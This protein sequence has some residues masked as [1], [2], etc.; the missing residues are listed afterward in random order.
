VT[1]RILSSIQRRFAYRTRH[2]VWRAPG[3]D[4]TATV[5]EGC[6]LVRLNGC[7]AI[8]SRRLVE[9]AMRA[10]DEPPGL[11][12][13][14]LAHGDECFGWLAH[15]E[16]VSFAWVTYRDRRVGSVRLAHAAGRAFV[17]NA[18]T[19]TSSRGRGLYTALLLAIRS[20]LGRESVKECVIDANSRNT[21]SIRG[22]EKAGFHKVAD[23]AYVTLFTC[24]PVFV[25][26][27]IV[28]AAGC[29]LF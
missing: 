1:S 16:I 22:I 3:V 28:D 21:P 20:V 13:A 26:R 24:W 11:V 12:E 23:I 9:A 6:D 4:R 15:G 10:A 8:D 5:P 14:R 19:V 27:R 17:F 29:S 7:A 25:Q 2:V 18:H